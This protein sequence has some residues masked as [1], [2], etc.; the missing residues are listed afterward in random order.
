MDLLRLPVYAD[1]KL[2][3]EISVA[4]KTIVLEDSCIRFLDHDGLVKILQRE[5]LG[6]VP[7]VVRFRQVLAKEVMR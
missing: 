1:H 7:T 6:V 4:C 5:A 3:N 2:V